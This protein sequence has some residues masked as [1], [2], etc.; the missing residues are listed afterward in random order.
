MKDD[1]AIDAVRDVRHRISEAVGHDPEKLVEYYRNRQE[2][3]R[4]RVVSRQTNSSKPTDD[5]AA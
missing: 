4:S 5:N 2:Q 1:P 3:Q